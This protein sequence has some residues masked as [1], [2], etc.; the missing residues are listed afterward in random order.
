MATWYRCKC[1]C[2]IPTKQFAL[3]QPDGWINSLFYFNTEFNIFSYINFPSFESQF[4]VCTDAYLIYQYFSSY[5]LWLSTFSLTCTFHQNSVRDWKH[6]TAQH[7]CNPNTLLAWITEILLFTAVCFIATSPRRRMGFRGRWHTTTQ[8]PALLLL[9]VEELIAIASLWVMTGENEYDLL[10]K[11]VIKKASS[12]HIFY[13]H[14]RDSCGITICQERQRC[15]PFS[16]NR[17][18]PFGSSIFHLR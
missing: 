10:T 11:Y 14:A 4:A 12:F 3:E 7:N 17:Q 13:G 9:I 15:L 18:A 6:S 8:I 5:T 16:S 1:I 2:L